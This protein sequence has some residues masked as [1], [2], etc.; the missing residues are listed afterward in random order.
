MFQGMLLQKIILE[1]GSK[2]MDHDGSEPILND[3]SQSIP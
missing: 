1:I 2:L 3:V